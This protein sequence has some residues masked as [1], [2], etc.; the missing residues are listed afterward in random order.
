VL[1]ARRIRAALEAAAVPLTSLR[2]ASTLEN[3]F[4]ALLRGMGDEPTVPPLPGGGAAPDHGGPVAIG[5]RGLVK[6]YRDFT[7]VRELTRTVRY[8]DSTGCWVQTGLA[9]P[10]R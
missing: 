7:A 6:Q 8:G 5:A 4:V 1:G 3:T 10:R 9:R 2:R